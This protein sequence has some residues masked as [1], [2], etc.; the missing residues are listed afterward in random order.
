M[1]QNI[2]EMLQ[3]HRAAS[4]HH[5]DASTAQRCLK[6]P[7]RCFNTIEMPQNTIELPQNPQ[8]CLKKAKLKAGVQ[9]NGR[10]WAQYTYD[11]GLNL[12]YQK[13]KTIKIELLYDPAVT[14]GIRTK[15]KKLISKR[16]LHSVACCGTIHK[17]LVRMV[18]NEPER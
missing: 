15:E 17:G 4:N 2:I 12:Q 11:I 3:Q 7:Q 6:T 9:L 8:I 1:P 5:R 18:I 10:A 13:K 16:Y 14:I